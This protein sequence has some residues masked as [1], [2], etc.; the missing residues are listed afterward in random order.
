MELVFFGALA[1]AAAVVLVRGARGAPM[2]VVAVALVAASAA[3]AFAWRARD[4]SRQRADAAARAPLPLPVADRGYV[5]SDS[6]RA[7]HPSEYASWHRSYHRTMTQPA[8]GAA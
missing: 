4:A 2:L 5:T 7:C 3:G 8:S 1:G 6:C